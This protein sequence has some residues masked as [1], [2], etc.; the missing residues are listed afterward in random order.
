MKAREL[1]EKLS[2]VNPDYEVFTEGCDCD[3]DSVDVV[4]YCEGAVIITRSHKYRTEGGVLM[5]R[6]APSN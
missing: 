2:H 3:G 4:D 5:T 1:T 6:Q